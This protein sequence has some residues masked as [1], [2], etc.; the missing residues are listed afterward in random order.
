MSG[1]SF[2]IFLKDFASSSLNKIS[3]GLSQLQSKVTA[4]QSNIQKNVGKTAFSI[5]ELRL[6]LDI[7]NSKRTASKSIDDIRRLK[8]E[9]NQVEREIKKLESLPPKGF[10]ERLRGIGSQFGGL[11]GLAGGM[12]IAMSAWN[13]IKSL[14]NLGVDMEQTNIK[15]NV[16]LGSAEK[17]GKLLG[18]LNQYA[19]FTPYS[20]E[21]IIKGAETMLGFGIAQEKIMGNMRMLGDV[22]MGNEE[23]LGSLSLVY[24]QVMATGR[25]MGQD[26]LQMINQGFNPL[27]IISDNTGISMG[28]LKQKMEDG[29]IS[30]EM[31]E[32]AFRLATSEGGRYHNM[33]NEMA[34][35]AGG[36]WSTMMGTFK[37]Q[38]SRVGMKFAEWIKPIFD[39]GTAVA[40]KIVPFGQTILNLIRY[41]TDCKPLLFFLGVVVGGLAI[42]FLIANA[43]T[44]AFSVTLGILEGVIWLV[45]AATTAWNFIMSMNPISLVII[46]IAALIAIVWA[47]WNK[48]EGFRGVI[49]GIW[50]VIK[51]FGTAIKEY[52]I[53]R[54][55]E[56][57]S[58]ITGIGQAL[59]AFFS[60]DFKKAWE[61]G[62]KAASDLIGVDSKKKFVEDGIN[63]AK[64]FNEGY[65]KGV[66]MGAPEVVQKT[67][68]PKSNAERAKQERSSVF[69]ALGN[70]KG[71]GTA[72]DKTKDKASGTISGGTKMTHI[73]INIEKLQDDTKIYV[74]STESGLSN[75]GEKV[76]EM[77]LRAVNSV[78]QMQTG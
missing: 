72:G 77:L 9:I 11:I 55:K 74:D 20:N 34:D 76:Q 15:F 70:A 25:L 10:G 3:T 44:I 19:N 65:N 39:I 41:V 23:K 31:V 47:L 2:S 57:L 36:K 60:G 14:F 51:G 78:N 66:K 24:S 58:G 43:S 18:D 6:K 27:Q 29:A 71:K 67:A 1:Y 12:A 69:D 7:L 17:A 52:V 75:L 32:E 64:K 5:D 21:G 16:L 61:V 53:N 49:M 4:S 62:K 45:S 22:A 33:A 59:L 73:T 35:T 13:G 8:T 68:N 48:F 30:A 56:L 37:N 38:L 28:V 26:L 42:N 54:F 50:E 63:A 40:E 46:A